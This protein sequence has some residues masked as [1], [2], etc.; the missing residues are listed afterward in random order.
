MESEAL[1]LNGFTSDL[2]DRCQSVIVDGILFAPSPLV[3]GIPRGSVSGPVLFTLYS[4]PLSDVIYA[5]GCD[6]HK[7]ADGTQLILTKRTT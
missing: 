5:L 3:S 6:S 4:Q 2:S 7:Y 1:L